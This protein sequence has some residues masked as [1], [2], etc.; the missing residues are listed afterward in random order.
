MPINPEKL[1]EII[2]KSNLLKQ[3]RFGH[4]L[5]MLGRN[6][7]SVSDRDHYDRIID[8]GLEP[9]GLEGFGLM[10]IHLYLLEQGVDREEVSEFTSAILAHHSIPGYQKIN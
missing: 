7:R 6:G 9:I 5:L 8:L 2:A 4:S 3:D 10:A 1:Q